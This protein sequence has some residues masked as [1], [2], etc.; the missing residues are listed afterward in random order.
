M[1]AADVVV[2]EADGYRVGL[3]PLDRIVGPKVEQIADLPDD[4][5]IDRELARVAA[6]RARRW[7]LSRLEGL[8]Y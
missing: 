3:T 2:W 8:G 5:Q 1:S 6:E 7:P 4:A